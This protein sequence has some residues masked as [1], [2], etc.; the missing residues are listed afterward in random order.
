MPAILLKDFERW[1]AGIA[2]AD[3][4]ANNNAQRQDVLNRPVISTTLT[5]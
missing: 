4:P 5:A 3:I 2:Q 1:P